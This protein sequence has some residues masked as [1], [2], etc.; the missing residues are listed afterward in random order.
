MR[1]SSRVVGFLFC[2]LFLMG[3]QTSRVEFETGATYSWDKDHR[4]VAGLLSRPAGEGRS[5]AVVLLHTCGGLLPHVTLDWPGY[6]TGLGYVV[7]SVDSYTPRG[8]SRCDEMGTWKNDQ[9]K[10]AFGA[11][12]YLA[13]LPFVDGE[14]I[15]VMGFS[16][17]AFAINDYV[18]NRSR[19]RTGMRNYKA[20]ISLYGRCSDPLRTY[21]EKDIPLMQIIGELDVFRSLCEGMRIDWNVSIEVHVLKGAYHAFDHP[22][23]TSKRLNLDLSRGEHLGNPMLYDA[24]KTREA[25]E[26][27]RAFLDK[28]L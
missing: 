3:F 15:A 23:I 27:T 7:L 28:H 5:P 4:Q 18:I 12:D 16:A 13:G 26:L 17:G 19:R 21:T 2:A 22:Q 1:R 24:A 11:L 25:R 9:T 6:L 10:D 14:R 20:A 8:Y